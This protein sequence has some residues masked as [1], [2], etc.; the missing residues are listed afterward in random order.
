MMCRAYR[1]HHR[2]RSARLIDRCR[3]FGMPTFLLLG[4]YDRHVPAELA[5]GYFEQI[6]APYK[7][8]MWFEESAQNPPFEEPDEFKRGPARR[9]AAF[10]LGCTFHPEALSARIREDPRPWRSPPGSSTTRSTG[11]PSVAAACSTMRGRAR[12][13]LSWF[14]MAG[15]AAPTPRWSVPDLWPGWAMSGSPA[16]CSARASVATSP[17]TT[18]P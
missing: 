17:A 8:P 1:P 15:K 16:T 6:E 18:A 14:A 3:S 4:R 13:P 7:R 5:E 10:L 12:G 9:S 11:R 2:A